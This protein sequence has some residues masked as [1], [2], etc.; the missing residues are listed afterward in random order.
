MAGIGCTT[1]QAR[2]SSTRMA[3]SIQVIYGQ[4]AEN[5]AEQ[6]Q[7][8]RRRRKCGAVRSARQLSHGVVSMESVIAS[9]KLADHH[10]AVPGPA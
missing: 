8:H 10:C 3:I 4:A 6:Q 1:P 5:A 9:M 2:P 7:Q